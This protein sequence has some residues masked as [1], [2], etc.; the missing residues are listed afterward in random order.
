MGTV[1]CPGHCYPGTLVKGDNRVL[2]P[3][4]FENIG[5]YA[6]QKGSHHSLKCSKMG[7]Y[8]A[9]TLPKCAGDKHG[10]RVWANVNF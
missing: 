5:Y 3:A 8:P 7:L 4:G 1:R 2:A 9:I 6:N 10:G